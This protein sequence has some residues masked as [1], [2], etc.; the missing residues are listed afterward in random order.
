MISKDVEKLIQTLGVELHLFVDN[1]QDKADDGIHVLDDPCSFRLLH[2]LNAEGFSLLFAY[3]IVEFVRIVVFFKDIEGKMMDI[4]V[5]F[6]AKLD[7]PLPD[8]APNIFYQKVLIPYAHLY[9]SKCT[10]LESNFEMIS[11][12]YWLELAIIG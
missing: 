8:E 12:N 5:C 11:Y 6:L 4:V 9:R 10:W 3:T 1:L 2:S 7:V